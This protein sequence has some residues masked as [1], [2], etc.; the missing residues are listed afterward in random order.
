MKSLTR[1]RPVSCTSSECGL[2][3]GERTLWGRASRLPV[4]AITQPLAHP[5]ECGLATWRGLLSGE[6]TLWGRASSVPVRAV[7]QPLAVPRECG[8]SNRGKNQTPGLASLSMPT[9]CHPPHVILS[10]AKDPHR[11]ESADLARSSLSSSG[12]LLH[13]PHTCHPER[14]EGSPLG[15]ERA[16]RSLVA[17]FFG[18]AFDTIPLALIHPAFPKKAN[19]P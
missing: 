9:S 14:S 15:Q 6:R 7:T 1:R 2:S 17:R 5:R 16:H 18:G 13:H 3:P 4:R 8:P 11:V 19:H 12:G 10:E